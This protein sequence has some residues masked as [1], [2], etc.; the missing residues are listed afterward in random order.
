MKNPLLAIALLL[1]TLT[2]IAAQENATDLLAKAAEAFQLNQAK[3]AHWT[4]TVEEH[5]FTHDVAG[6]TIQQFPVVKV[7]SVI[8][9]DGR[10]CEAIVS[11]SD[12]WEPYPEGADNDTRCQIVEIDVDLPG[13]ALQKL[14]KSR[15]AAIVEINAAQDAASIAITISPDKHLPSSDPLAK[16]AAVMQGTVQLDRATLF[17]Q[18]IRAEVVANGCRFKNGTTTWYLEKGTSFE[19]EY[20]LQKD[21][22]GKTENDFWILSRKRVESAPEPP[23]IYIVRNRKFA[24]NAPK[25]KQGL[26]SE[27]HTVAQE[28][29]SQSRISFEK[30]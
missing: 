21:R 17:P 14:L 7:E 20:A 4:W 19:L 16:C 8:R 6:K 27:F 5:A 1:A 13:L 29:G 11:W 22:F 12:G 24:P 2:P 28:F 15:N 26:V 30:P 10:R 18:A 9:S 3:E 23:G 25:V